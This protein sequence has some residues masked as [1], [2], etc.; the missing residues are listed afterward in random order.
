VSGKTNFPTIATICSD[1]PSHLS[2][3]KYKCPR[4]TTRTCSLECSKRHKI[5]AQCSGI[6][7]QAAFIT[8]GQLF[9]AEAIDHD[10]NFLSSI[11]RKVTEADGHGNVVSEK[12]RMPRRSKKWRNVAFWNAVRNANVHVHRA[13]SGIS[14]EKENKSRLL[15]R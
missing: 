10:F 7:D 1:F 4:C 5:R 11:E 13:P 12:V 6:R 14:R 9:T 15:Q 8:K 3:P 2:A